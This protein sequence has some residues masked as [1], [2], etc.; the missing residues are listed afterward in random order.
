MRPEAASVEGLRL[1]LGRVQIH[2]ADKLKLEDGKPR[3]HEM[4]RGDGV[5]KEREV[6]SLGGDRFLSGMG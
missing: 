2:N 1:L 4:V 5:P 3:T 6:D